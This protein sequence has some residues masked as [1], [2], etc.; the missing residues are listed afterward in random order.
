MATQESIARVQALYVAY[1]GR[2][3]DQEGLDYWADRLDAEGEGAII[4]AFGNSAEY[5]E[6]SEGQGNATLI[7]AIYQQ[8]FGREADPEGLTYYAGVLEN[9]EKTLAEI[10]TT[11][12]NAAGGQDRLVLNA[13]VEAAAAYT[14]E[15]GEA[16]EYDLEAAKAAVEAA[17][18]SVDASA[19]TEALTTLKDAQTAQGEY[20]EGQIDTLNDMLKKAAI[21]EDDGS[22]TQIA[23]KLEDDA[24]NTR[25]E[26][27]ID[28]VYTSAAGQVKGSTLLTDTNF[29]TRS[30]AAQDLLISDAVAD[31]QKAITAAEKDAKDGVLSAIAT[32]QQRANSLE[33]RIDQ[34]NAAKKAFDVAEAAFEVESD[35]VTSIAF[36]DADSDDR[37]SDGDT[38]T[39]DSAV[40]LTFQGNGTW[41]VNDESAAAAIDGLDA[42]IELANT[43]GKA[44][45]T[46]NNAEASLQTAI[47]ATLE[48]Q[49]VDTASNGAISIGENADGSADV[50]V[51]FEGD[52]S[53]VGGALSA[54]TG[55]LNEILAAR[56]NLS[57]FNEAVAAF[58]SIRTIRDEAEA[59]EK[60]VTDAVEAIEDTEDGLDVDVWAEGASIDLDS[61]TD[62]A[63]D[64]VVFSEDFDGETI[65]NFGTTGEDRIFFGEEFSLVQLSSADG[66]AFAAGT[67]FSA[68]VGNASALEVFW[69]QSGVNVELFVENKAFAGNSEGDADFTKITLAGVNS[70]DL[71]FSNGYLTAGE[72][73]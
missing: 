46:T 3:A 13:R 62:V 1:Y 61:P 25:I 49:E 39:V 55:D 2:P 50:D 73:A 12:I 45:I 66:Q 28:A 57:N 9:G 23:F 59:N 30:T 21:T 51:A 34:E 32:V 36:V 18:A 17:K 43:W 42:I 41:L 33:N 60:A 71:G 6:L 15:F 52:F 22:G 70:D 72:P 7:N 24:S 37:P 38:I 68:D 4:N 35:D 44:A 5:T 20:L 56:E 48:L 27:A 58:E 67:D 31:G 54:P 26:S 47:D 53:G 14:A 65:T 10:A 63:D 16:G 29:E 8:A 64:V 19:L 11:I 69:T 40:T